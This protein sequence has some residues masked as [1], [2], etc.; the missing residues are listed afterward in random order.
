MRLFISSISLILTL[1]SIELKAQIQIEKSV[2]FDS[3]SS[4]LDTN[5]LEKLTADFSEFVSRNE[6]EKIVIVGHTDHVGSED[7]NMKLSEK[8]A[9]TV[10][11][12]LVAFGV[13]TSS[14]EYSYKG[15]NALINSSSDESGKAK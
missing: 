3:N 2:Y 12:E 6:L 8:R 14:I 9:K 10:K 15:E 4:N 1:F 5:A 11:S 13:S 7:Y